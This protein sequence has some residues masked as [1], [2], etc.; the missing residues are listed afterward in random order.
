M[1]APV[2]YLMIACMES[3][4]HGRFETTEPYLIIQ[5]IDALYAK[6]ART[7][8]YEVTHALWNFKMKEGA[9][10]SE[11]VIKIMGFGKR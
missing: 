11:H 3:D 4:L 6:N 8:R 5:E 9:P 2:Q 1:M 10:V 7:E